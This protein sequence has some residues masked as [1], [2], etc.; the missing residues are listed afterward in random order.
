MA[1][2]GRSGATS[3]AAIRASRA[4]FSAGM[5]SIMSRSTPAAGQ[6]ANLFGKGGA[7]FVQ[8]GLAQRLQA[9]AERTDR[10]G[11]PGF[12][13]L[14]LLQVLDGLAG[15]AHAGGVDL[16]HFAG[17]AVAG[18]P[19]AVGAKGVGL[20]NLR[21]RL[22]VLFVDGEDQAGIGEVEFVVAAVDEDAAA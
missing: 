10:A 21:A 19:E 22:Q 9:N 11:H 7:R 1:S 8:A 12:A 4:S 15:Q 17:Q 6:G 3:R 14:L 16:R 20:K 13:G 2:T 18:Q 5:V